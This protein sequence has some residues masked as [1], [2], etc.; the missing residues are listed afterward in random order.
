MAFWTDAQNKDPKRAF[1]F[2]V[3]IGGMENGATWYAKAVT[4]PSITIEEASHTFLNH[5][6][7]YPG[8]TTW[9][10]VTVTLVDPVS[11]DAAANT[12]AILTASGYSPPKNVDDV[13]TMSKQAAVKALSG[14]S[15][16]Q[17]DST[18]GMLEKWTLWNAFLTEVTYGDLSYEEDGLTEVTLKL[19]YDWAV[20]ETANKSKTGATTPAGNSADGN[21]FFKPGTK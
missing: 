20:L 15:I 14:V 10:E 7:H 18:G 4:K 6:F 16:K 13:T 11:P 19:R 8:R 2:M 9:S 12:A 3:T 5:K 17:I 1:R 21:A